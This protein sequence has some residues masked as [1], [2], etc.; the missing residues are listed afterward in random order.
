MH[1]WQP[2]LHDNLVSR[3]HHLSEKTT[4]NSTL[5]RTCLISKE[6]IDK[7][8]AWKC[9]PY[10]SLSLPPHSPNV[11][12]CTNQPPHQYLGGFVFQKQKGQALMSFFVPAIL[13]EPDPRF[14]NCRGR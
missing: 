11:I 5:S 4:K 6:T 13:L 14:G 2:S 7:N 1:M 3:Q 12:M 10:V 8:L 9:Q